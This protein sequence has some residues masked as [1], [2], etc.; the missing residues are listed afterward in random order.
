MAP[1]AR[2][3]RTIT[4]FAAGSVAIA[5]ALASRGRDE[6]RQTAIPVALAERGDLE[7]TLVEPGALSAAQSLTL[8]SEIRSNRAKIVSL[9]ADGTWVKPG[10]AVVSFDPTPFEEERDKAAA[11]LRDAEAAAAR[12]EQERKL[13]V[14]KAEESRESARHAAKIATLNLESYEK[15]NGALSVR[16]AEVRAAD[17]GSEL[18]RTRRDLADIEQMFQKGFVSEAELSRQRGRMADVE[19]QSRLQS[20]RLKAA[21]EVIF[22]RDLERAKS[23]LAETKDEVARAEAV[24]YHSQEFYRAAVDAAQGKVESARAALARAE[25]EL[26]KTT[27]RSTIEGFL[28]LQD[29][30][31]DSG[32]RKPQVGDSVW[33]GQ[34]I[35]TIPD[36]SQMV[37]SARIRE[38]D[39]HR[40]REGLMARLDL[41]AYPDLVMNGRIDFIGSLAEA[42][43]D[44][45]WKFFSV[46]LLVDR[47]DPRLRPGMSVRVSFLLD[48]AHGVV[49]APVDAVFPCAGRSCCYVRR[50]GQIWEQPV[51]L[52]LANETH[53]EVKSGL[54]AGDEL[55]LAVPEAG[56][57]RPAPPT[58]GA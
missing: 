36:L 48:A 44:S 31:L 30:P 13:Q 21:R 11:E 9:L 55:L 51:A 5:I 22:P 27:L 12:A 2:R 4:L 28:V 6:G 52:G 42:S 10:D 56:F 26:R 14:A 34:A 23:E 19:R 45:P 29:I 49:V 17:S 39:L 35:A 41:E 1:S 18:D 7:I 20:D 15:G 24:V 40:I 38:N 16:E 57:R 50:A 43:A 32:R 25:E 47:T 53:V 58:A 54:A 33:S 46:R 37:V 8:S 3:R